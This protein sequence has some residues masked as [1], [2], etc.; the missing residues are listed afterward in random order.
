LDIAKYERQIVWCCQGLEGVD[1]ERLK[2]KAHQPLFDGISTVELNKNLCNAARDLQTVEEPNWTFVA[3]RF[4][5]QD[6]YKTVNGEFKYQHL[7]SYLKTAINNTNMNPALGRHDLFDI[8]ELHHAIDP[9]RDYKFDY[10]GLTTLADRYLLRDRNQKTIEMPQHFL[11]RVSMG[12][13]LAEGTKEKRTAA[14]L[15]YY[16]ML[17]NLHFM[18]STPTLFNSGMKRSQLS[19]CFGATV[20]DDTD[21]IT[22]VWKEVSKYSKFGG[23][24]AMDYTDLRSNGSPIK[25]MGGEAEGP[26]PYIA[27]ADGIFRAF[28]Q[29]GKRKGSVAPYL[30]VWHADIYAYLDLKEPGDYRLRANDSFMALWIPDLFMERVMAEGKWSLFDPAV[31]GHLHDIY[32]DEFKTEYE[33]LEAEGKFKQQIDALEL[34]YRMLE[35]LSAHGVFWHCYKDRI[36]ERYALPYIIKSSNLCT[37]ICLRSDELR[38]F[39]CNLGSIN[40]SRKEHHLFRNPDGSWDW[41]MALTKSVWEAV[42]FLDSVIDIGFVP[43]D[44]GESMQKSDRPI[45]LGVM[46]WTEALYA[47]GIDYESVEHIEYA[48]EFYKQVSIAATYASAQLAKEKGSFPEFKNSTWAQGKLIHDSLKNRK[49]IDEFDLDLDFSYCPFL[50]NETQLREL[51]T[52]GMRNSTLLAI[53]PTATISNIVGTEACTE[54]PVEVVYMKKNLSGVFKAVA[55]TAC[56]NPHNL[57]IKTVYQIDNKWTARAAAARQIWIDQSQSTNAWFDSN[58]EDYGDKL[59]EYYRYTWAIGL[60]TTYYMYGKDPETADVKTTPMDHMEKPESD[61]PAPKFCALDDPTCESCQ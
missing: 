24:V 7:D 57:P 25:S 1:P 22:D 47:L 29:Q 53:A 13:A 58:D 50:D 28:N 3:A 43:H 48:N 44:K 27:V 17:S 32:G 21:L 37:E 18:A 20:G 52:S 36:N 19:S 31:A 60:K 41:N 8:D 45:G 16:D 11:M 6:L 34:W 49:I 12:V 30:E 61:S 56:N 38:S 15:R 59:D 26:V 39:V 46:G 4:V 51:V 54:L 10:L 55:K 5:L 23:G 9:A 2:E 40:A 33:R 42:R 14:A 35:R